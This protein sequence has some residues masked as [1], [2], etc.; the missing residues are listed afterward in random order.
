MRRWP[1]AFD[2]AG[3]ETVIGGFLTV[4]Q[5]VFLV[6]HGLLAVTA[7]ALPLAAAIPLAVVSIS[8]GVFLAFG[9]L[10][11]RPSYSALWAWWRYRRSPKLWKGGVQ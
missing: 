3:P 10:K 5:L 9:R 11:G 6:G 1:V 8:A 4:P 7:F 2:L